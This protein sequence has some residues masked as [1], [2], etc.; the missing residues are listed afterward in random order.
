MKYFLFII[1]FVFIAQ[2]Y[3]AQNLFAEAGFGIGQLI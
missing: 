1:L 3:D 2:F